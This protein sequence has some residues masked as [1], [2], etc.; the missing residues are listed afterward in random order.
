MS[1]NITVPS[2]SLSTLTA[3]SLF[4]TTTP[5]NASSK[6]Y[7]FIKQHSGVHLSILHRNLTANAS[8]EN[9][10]NET[11]ERYVICADN[12][13]HVNDRQMHSCTPDI[14]V[15]CTD[16]KIF[17]KVFKIF[18]FLFFFLFFHIYDQ[19][20]NTLAVPGVTKNKYIPIMSHRWLPATSLFSKSKLHT[21]TNWKYLYYAI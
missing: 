9:E 7:R 21:A 19:M 1:S 11:T 8:S 13:S 2:G 17:L 12:I 3:T 14:H 10:D 15:K 16:I 5:Q 18:S 20:N 6:T 4:Y